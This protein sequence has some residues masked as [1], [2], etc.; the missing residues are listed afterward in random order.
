LDGVVVVVSGGGAWLVVVVPGA[1]VAVVDVGR[2][3]VGGAV[4]RGLTTFLAV[5]AT[6]LVGA[7]VVVVV[8][9]GGG[10]V[11]SG[12]AVVAVVDGDEVDVEVDE[13]T[14][15]PTGSGTRSGADPG[16]PAIR[17]PAPTLMAP[18][19]AHHAMARRRSG[20]SHSTCTQPV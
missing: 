4:T 15:A 14:S 12:D 17:N 7:A 16:G 3:V 1:E 9:G 13:V 11:V 10:A 8:S 20:L 6:G 19:N 18:T 5:V 2:A